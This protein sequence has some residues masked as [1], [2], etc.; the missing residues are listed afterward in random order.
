MIVVSLEA[1][2][3][4]FSVS[5]VCHKPTGNDIISALLQCALLSLTAVGWLLQSPSWH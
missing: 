5:V 1:S 4:T 2:C 3:R